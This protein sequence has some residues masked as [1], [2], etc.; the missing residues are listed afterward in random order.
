M[1]EQ[2]MSEGAVAD[3]G[4]AQPDTASTATAGDWSGQETNPLAFNRDVLPEEL[5]L[6]PSLQSFD[7]VDK[8]AKSY[9]HAVRKLGVPADE[10][11]RMPKEMT[12]EHMAEI[13][14]RLGRPNSADEYVLDSSNELTPQYKALAHEIG[15]NQAQAQ[16]L[17]DWYN[18]NIGSQAQ[19]AQQAMEQQDVE[20]LK[21]LQQEWK[22][23][24]QKNSDLAHRAF[25]RFGDEAALQALNETGLGNH[26]S[27]VKMFHQIGRM[28]AEDG[29]LHS[30]EGMELGGMSATMAQ[31]EINNL[32]NN[33]EFMEA[34][35][36]QYHPRHAE[37][38]RKMKSL[39]EYL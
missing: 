36:D 19:Q 10:L 14:E 26:P 24:F 30:G 22:G 20:H 8:L 21:Q 6:E 27:I 11:V 4:A 34:Y 38:V 16:K 1:T 13:Y 3:T 39:Y 15:L 5:R 32:M 31:G 23:D 35:L 17:H 28:L 12:P 33:G 25:K 9:V 7:S 2:M 29:S 37:S 18:E